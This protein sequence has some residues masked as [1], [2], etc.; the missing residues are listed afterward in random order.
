MRG[1]FKLFSVSGI[2]IRLHATFPL[3]LLWAA[4]QFGILA[5]GGTAGALFGVVIV[6]L[7]FVLVTLHELGHSFAARYFGV[8]V[9]RIVLLPIGGVAQ[10]KHM[11]RKPHQEFVIAI[12]G[13]LVNVVVGIVLLLL[14]P[15]LGFSINNPALLLSGVPELTI[16]TIS[17]YLFYYNAALAIFNMIPAFPMDGGRVLRSFLAMWMDYGR[18]TRIATT[19]GRVLA[20]GLG[21][22]GLFNGGISLLLIALF[23]YNGAAQE[24][25]FVGRTEKMRDLKVVHAYSKQPLVLSPYDNLQRAINYRQTGLQQAFP[26]VYAGQLIGFL[27]E[28]DLSLAIAE[29]PLW[30]PIKD[31]MIQ[32]INPVSEMSRLEDVEA[33]MQVEHVSALPVVNGTQF[34]GLI[35]RRQIAE[36]IR[37]L[38]IRPDLIKL[39]SV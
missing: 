15:F 23:V 34:L 17:G 9:E 11:P 6:S 8:P 31:I 30:T 19:I 32:N 20:V 38:R 21:L 14:A 28:Q 18:S 27:R 36:I 25:R 26:V 7:L 37:T 5:N 4:Y 13:P 1:S 22:Y 35:T 24:N 39:Q 16:A 33:R 3:I 12:A 10:L 2:D 29:K